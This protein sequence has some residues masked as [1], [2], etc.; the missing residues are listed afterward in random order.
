MGIFGDT[1]HGAST[2]VEALAEV[3]DGGRG[4]RSQVPTRSPEN[5]TDTSNAHK[6]SLRYVECRT[7]A[8]RYVFVDVPGSAVIAD[9]VVAAAQLDALILVVS[10]RDGVTA[11]TAEL[12]FLARYAGVPHALVA[13]TKVDAADSE[14]TDVA[15]LEAADLL[16]HGG[17]VRGGALPT[18][19]HPTGAIHLVQAAVGTRELLTVT[20]VSALGALHGDP[21]GTDTIRSLLGA[22]ETLIPPPART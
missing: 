21:W 3:A 18:D 5:V 7:R 13:V 6:Y 2:L 20:S 16:A 9:V 11:R 15:S 19:T 4:R 8:R 12:L 10:A 14:L 1:G 17:Q 22:L